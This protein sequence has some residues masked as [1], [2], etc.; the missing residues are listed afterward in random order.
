MHCNDKRRIARL[1]APA[2]RFAETF[3]AGHCERCTSMTL[4]ATH[5]SVTEGYR[6]LKLD[7]DG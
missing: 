7:A 2:V 6:V 4:F 5:D 3:Q 1:P